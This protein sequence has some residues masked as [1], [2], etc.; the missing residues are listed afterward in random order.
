MR[1]LTGF[2][3]VNVYQFLPD[4]SGKVL[5]EDHGPGIASFL[6]LHYPASDI[7]QQARE[8]YRRT[9][10]HA[11]PD[12]DYWPAPLL[13]CS[14]VRIEQP[15]DM[16]YCGL[17]SVSPIH[18]EYLRNMGVTASMSL[19]IIVNDR[20]WGLIACHNYLPRYLA[21]DLRIACELYA[22]IFSL[23]LTAKIETDAAR[24]R[25]Q[26]R[27]VQAELANRIGKSADLV[28]E[29]LDGDVSILDLI[30]ATGVALL[31][32]GRLLT[33]GETPSKDAIRDLSDWLKAGSAP[34]FQSSFLSDAFAPAAGYRDV[35]SG[36]LA[37][38]VA[39]D[40]SCY[41]MW[42]RPELTRTVSWGGNPTKPIEQGPHGG[43]LSPRK[44]F[45][46][47][48]SEVRG[49]SAPWDDI[50]V[51][52]A[53]AFRV[54]LLEAVLGQMHAARRE[55]EAMIARQ[56]VL[57][58]ELDHRVKNTLA[59]IH[60]LVRESKSSGRSLE[61]FVGALEKRITVMG[62][63]HTLLADSHWD[64]VS[65]RSLIEKESTVLGGAHQARVELHGHD[66]GLSATA[67]MTLSMVLHELLA[68]AERYGAL[69]TPAGRIRLAWSRQAGDG[70]LVIDWKELD[71]PTVA[72]PSRRGFGAAIIERSLGNELQGSSVV[73]YAAD[74]LACTLTVPSAHL[75]K[76]TAD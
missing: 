5:A 66:C 20:L 48:K 49:Q 61:E 42:L 35:A 74:G 17:R 38:A 9:W 33:R 57:L 1:E 72:E 73:T 32:E 14:G 11:I 26:P 41:V 63:A 36:L 67:T 54:W 34:V 69:S 68:N 50:E 19:S 31:Y 58:D 43:R 15:L 3:R 6:H 51:D 65:L 23:H 4:G 45:E 53:S 39:H 28:A 52:A 8:M 30:P 12:V 25:I 70:P 7:P 24:R 47:W 76:I 13:A 64:G 10:I 46:A 62:N 71:G 44:S 56:N 40:P 55:R 2:D 22:Q 29:L 37:V 21:T 18:L 75:V 59:R 27:A 16:T 60:G